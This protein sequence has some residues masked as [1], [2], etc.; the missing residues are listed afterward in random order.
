MIKDQIITIILLVCLVAANI[1]CFVYNGRILHLTTNL[2]ILS[3][4][5][6]QFVIGKN[7][8]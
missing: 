7:R 2:A 4:V 3:L 1:L 8:G 6:I 5:A